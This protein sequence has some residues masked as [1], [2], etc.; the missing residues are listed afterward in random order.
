MAPPHKQLWALLSVGVY[1][2]RTSQALRLNSTPGCLPTS[3]LLP[4]AGP[5]SPGAPPTPPTAWSSSPL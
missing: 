3:P 4:T 2:T 1:P 5:F